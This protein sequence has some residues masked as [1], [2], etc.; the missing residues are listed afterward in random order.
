[1]LEKI[2]QISLLA[3]LLIIGAIAGSIWLAYSASA[4]NDGMTY[5]SKVFTST[6]ASSTASTRLKRIDGQLGSI[7]VGS[8]STSTISVYSGYSTTTGQLITTLKANI[9]EGTYTFDVDMQKGIV[10]DVPAT[11][12]GIYTITYR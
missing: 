6:D 10:V 3:S 1:M 4:S 11:F 2:K 12:D 8:S 7:I 9:A 5:Q